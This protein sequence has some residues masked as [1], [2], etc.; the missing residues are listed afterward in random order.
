MN[1]KSKIIFSILGILVVLSV[2]ATYYRYVILHNY[3]VETE[4]SC[5]PSYESCFV[6]TCDPGTEGECTSNPEEDTWY[7][8]IAHRNAK[9]I[10]LCDPDDVNCLPFQCAEENEEGCDE[11]ICSTD[12]LT[13][14]KLDGVCTNPADFTEPII[15]EVLTKNAEEE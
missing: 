6:W 15:E 3:L 1:K 5:D 2:S 14:Y 4:V 12:T 13:K 8:K 11:V 10:P 7:Y 9:N